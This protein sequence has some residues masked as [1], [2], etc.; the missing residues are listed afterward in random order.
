M[1]RIA[2]LIIYET[3]DNH[4]LAGQL[5]KSLA[6]GIHDKG[7]ITITVINLSSNSIFDGFVEQV[8]ETLEVFEENEKVEENEKI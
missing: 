6:E 2:R 3:E 5:S 4:T 1:P 8:S 7:Y